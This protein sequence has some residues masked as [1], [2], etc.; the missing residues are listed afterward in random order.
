MQYNFTENDATVEIKGE[1]TFVDHSLFRAMATRLLQ[2]KAQAPVIDL[3][4]LDFIDSA[5]LG[6]LL[7]VRDEAKRS[8]RKVV[9]RHPTGQV[10]RI[11]DISKFE[12]LFSVQP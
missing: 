2:A 7:L 1:L 3:S 5:G 11:F 10:K 6:M 12:R 4:H 9:L 8:N